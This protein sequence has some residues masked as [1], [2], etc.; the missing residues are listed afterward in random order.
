MRVWKICSIKEYKP[1]KICILSRLNQLALKNTGAAVR[2]YY[3]AKNLLALGHEVHIIIPGVRRSTTRIDGI[4]IHRINC[5]FPCRFLKFLC[6]LFRIISPNSLSFFDPSFTL[7][8]R[9]IILK[10][11]VIQIEGS[12]E[13]SLISIVLRKIFRRGV[14]IDAHDTFQALR[15]GH[16]SFIRKSLEVF[17][18]KI[19]YKYANLI[20]TVSEKEKGRLTKHGVCRDKIEIVPNGVDVNAF[21]R[22][23]NSRDHHFHERSLKEIYKIIFV[24]NMEYLP[25]W[26]SVQVI[27]SQIAP[28]VLSKV[29]NVKFLIVG[30]LPKKAK[31]IKC[32]S[33]NIVF[34]G[35]VKDV[36]RFL[37]DS[38]VAI[39]PL[40][41]GS[42]TRLKILEYFSYGLPV[43]S[44]SV[45]VEGLDVKDELNVL[46]EDVIDNFALKIIDLIK[47]RKLS[48]ELG[49]SAREL[50]VKKYD[51]KQ[52]AKQLENIY[53]SFIARNNSH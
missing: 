49:K 7:R 42:G 3:L 12:V 22:S 24:G 37:A 25:N 32:D 33:P 14:V 23:F 5:L 4:I 15:V 29:D 13:G 51:W 8:A 9:H 43:I 21:S 30:R 53:H 47:N 50:V 41:H 20:L 38:D 11:D 34:T 46:I 18:E 35:V 17:A 36:S 28:K 45:G 48:T 10:S 39:A 52:I 6:N 1:I 44:T 26:E 27:V 2:I 31:F 40:L 16:S 19:S